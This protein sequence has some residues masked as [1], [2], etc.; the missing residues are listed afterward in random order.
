MAAA[1]KLERRELAGANPQADVAVSYESREAISSA[2]EFHPGVG[3][4]T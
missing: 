2:T 4:N 3:A 1:R